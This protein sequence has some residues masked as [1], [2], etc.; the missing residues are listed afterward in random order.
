M[1]N[2]VFH[3]AVG[4]IVGAAATYA[5]CKINHTLP[6]VE[7]YTAGI[8]V[9]SF[10]ALLPDWLEPPFSRRHRGFFHSMTVLAA[11][12]IAIGILSTQRLDLWPRIVSLSF[13]SAYT[14]HLAC[15]LVVSGR[16][17]LIAKGL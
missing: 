14:S 7:H 15:D 2:R 12:A 13:T 6:S 4:I 9:A 17:P 11:L 10:G 3:E 8:I 16:L 1:P 5:S